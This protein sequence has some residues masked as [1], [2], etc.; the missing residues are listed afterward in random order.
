M[1]GVIGATG[2]IGREVT[3]Q[4]AARG[5][6]VRAIVRDPVKARELLGGE[7]AYVA[8]DLADPSTLPAAFAGLSA[9]FLVSPVGPSM[10]SLQRNAIDAAVAAGV[11]HV[12]RISSIAVGDPDMDMQ[13]VRWHTELDTR[14]QDSGL[15][16]TLLRPSN[17]MRNLLGLAAGVRSSGRIARAAGRR[18]D[19]LRR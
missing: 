17:F 11:E 10:V 2:G 18:A 14:L 4:L 6:P 15:A 5:V 16:W 8:A 19:V 1:I 9:L 12:V 13:F 3:G 7:P